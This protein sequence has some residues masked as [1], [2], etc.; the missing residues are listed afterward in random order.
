[1]LPWGIDQTFNGGGDQ[2]PFDTSALLVRECVEDAECLAAF[3]ERLDEV[4]VLYEGLDFATKA[5]AIHD[6]L[7]PHVYADPRKEY[8]NETWEQQ[9][10]DMLNWIPNRP[11]RVREYLAGAGF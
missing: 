9:H 1:V 5:A 10:A 6:Q 3:A 7:Q 8:S 2:N 4:T 11:A